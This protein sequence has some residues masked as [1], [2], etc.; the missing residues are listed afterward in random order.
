MRSASRRSP[1]KADSPE[2]LWELFVCAV[3]PLNALSRSLPPDRLSELR[4]AFLGFFSGY[5][6]EQGRVSQPREYV[7]VI[8]RR[9]D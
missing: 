8:G 5:V 6:D 7:I 3:G 1:Q 4:E 9:R 2:A